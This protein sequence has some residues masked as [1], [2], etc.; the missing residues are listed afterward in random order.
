L[1]GG[2]AN[3]VI[4]ILSLYAF[5]GYRLMPALQQ[6]YGGMTAVKYN[7]PALQLIIK[8]LRECDNTTT[9]KKDLVG[10]V[11]FKKSL[12]LES[13][14]FCYEGTNKNILTN[15]NLEIQC[16]TTVGIVG[17]T[18]SGKTTLVDIVLGLLTQNSGNIFVDNIQINS[19]NIS[20]WQEH[21]GYVPQSIF[22]TDD[23]I[24]RNIAF[25]L[26]DSEIDSSKIKKASKIAEL[27]SFINE[28]PNKYKTYVGERGV[29][30]SGGQRQ[31]IGIARALYNNPDLLVFD[32]ATSSLDGVTENAIVDAIHNLSNKKT[33]IMI[34]HRLSTVKEC[35]IIYVLENGSIVDSGK[36]DKLISENEYFK[37]VASSSF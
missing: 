14:N 20:L 26:S 19:D 23:T 31:R 12:Y 36:Y 29:R 4:P 27:D 28:L 5:A 9:N 1:K 34:A 10:S 11:A 3:E 13:I 33:I 7:M 15:L 16:R 2:N 18:G 35:D 24:E 32:E 8:D 22:L 6:I 37:K 17:S 30:L 25:S 21:L